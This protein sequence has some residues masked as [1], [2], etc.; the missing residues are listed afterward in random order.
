M[1]IYYRQKRTLRV[2]RAKG[3]EAIYNLTKEEQQFIISLRAMDP[4][5]RAEFLKNLK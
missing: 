2:L 5:E 4:E 1:M 3:D